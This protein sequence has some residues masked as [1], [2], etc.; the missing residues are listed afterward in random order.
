M[1]QI[2]PG[3]SARTDMPLRVFVSTYNEVHGY[4]NKTDLVEASGLSIT[5]RAAGCTLCDQIERLG[6]ILQADQ[7]GVLPDVVATE[8]KT[9]AEN[10]GGVTTAV[11]QGAKT[12]TA[13]AV[14]QLAF[15]Y[16]GV[17]GW[18]ASAKLCKELKK[19]DVTVFAVTCDCMEDEEITRLADESSADQIIIGHI[20]GGR[21]ELALIVKM[22]HDQWL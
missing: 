16:A 13:T 19:C 8:L 20:C 4:A 12:K 2:L 10:Q 18:E 11:L 5:I 6:V 17:M 9:T 15:I 1:A 7:L 22:I 21:Y 14:R 3:L